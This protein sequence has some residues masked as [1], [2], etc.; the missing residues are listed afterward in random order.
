[1]YKLT[2]LAVLMMAFQGHAQAADDHGEGITK[3]TLLKTETSW[4]GRPISIILPAL[5]RSPC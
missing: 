4:E 1:M 5:R 3:E 2:L